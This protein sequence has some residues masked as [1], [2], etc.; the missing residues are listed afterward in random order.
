MTAHGSTTDEPMVIGGQRLVT[1]DCDLNGNPYNHMF[2]AYTKN[3]N[4]Y[5]LSTAF[6]NSL[7]PGT[8]Y[9][10]LWYDMGNGKTERERCTITVAKDYKVTEI[11]GVNMYKDKNQPDVNWYQYSGKNLNFTANGDPNR[12]LGVKIDGKLINAGNYAVYKDTANGTT[13]V[14]LYPGYLATL[15]QGK[16]T[17]AIVFSDGEATAT[18]SVLGASAS[19]KTGD[20]NHLG[21][22]AGLLVFSGAAVVALIPKKKKQ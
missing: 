9:V 4:D 20:N 18:F 10:D 8:H 14:G 7:T 19:P 3:G 22:W 12:F 2:T 15:A 11:N 16:H 5:V 1:L 17:I 6:L 13:T 21:L